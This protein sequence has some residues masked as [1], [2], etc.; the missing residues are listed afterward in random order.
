M[1][2]AQVT[3]ETQ[4]RRRR[5]TADI[6]KRSAYRKKHGLE[7]EGFGGWTAK[8]D[9]DD[10]VAAVPTGVLVAAEDGGEMEEQAQRPKK[11]VKK[12]LGIW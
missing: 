5:Q 4:E 9:G 8:T 7:N 3:V 11:Q 1:H 6:Q 2:T 10:L 12:W